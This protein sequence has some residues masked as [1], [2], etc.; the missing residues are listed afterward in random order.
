MRRVKVESWNG[1]VELTLGQRR[2]IKVIYEDCFLER[3][4]VG[5]SGE[6]G[7]SLGSLAQLHSQH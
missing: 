5:M 1:V 4:W 6:A 2:L 3:T 7:S